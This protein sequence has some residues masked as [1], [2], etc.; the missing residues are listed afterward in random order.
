MKPC[1]SVAPK[2]TQ[3]RLANGFTALT[4]RA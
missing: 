3:R 1:L 4:G 2:V